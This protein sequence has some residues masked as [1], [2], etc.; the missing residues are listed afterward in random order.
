M[1]LKPPRAIAEAIAQLDSDF[2]LAYKFNNK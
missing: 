1:V 2:P